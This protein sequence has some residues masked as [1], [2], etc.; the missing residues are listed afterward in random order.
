[1][2]GEFAPSL[3]QV[4]TKFQ[5]RD[6]TTTHC[7]AHPVGANTTSTHSFEMWDVKHHCFV[8]TAHT[9]VLVGHQQTEHQSCQVSSCL[10]HT[11]SLPSL[12]RRAHPLSGLEYCRRPSLVAHQAPLFAHSGISYSPCGVHNLSLPTCS[13][14]TYRDFLELVSSKE[15]PATCDHC[16]AFVVFVLETIRTSAMRVIHITVKTEETQKLRIMFVLYCSA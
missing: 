2:K 6:G 10:P 14:P 9:A 16:G 4:N 12:Q 1:M 8:C 5:K 13:P 15:R 11:R 7:C 3:L